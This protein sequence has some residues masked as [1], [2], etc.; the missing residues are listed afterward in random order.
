MCMH[1]CDH[2]YIVYT[3]ILEYTRKV[4]AVGR[5]WRVMMHD[6][7]ICSQKWALET[8]AFRHQ[9]QDWPVELRF[10]V[11]ASIGVELVE[12]RLTEDSLCAVLSKVCDGRKTAIFREPCS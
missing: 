11:Q 10:N 5:P 9:H 8:P 2:V 12:H 6:A 7:H 1:V 3:H 4:R